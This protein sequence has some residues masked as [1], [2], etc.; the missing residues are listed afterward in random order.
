MHGS[1]HKLLGFTP[2]LL[3]SAYKFPGFAPAFSHCLDST[4]HCVG[5]GTSLLVIPNIPEGNWE[6]VLVKDVQVHLPIKLLYFYH[7]YCL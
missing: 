3:S 4:G 1:A 5:S 7:F 2:K 6:H